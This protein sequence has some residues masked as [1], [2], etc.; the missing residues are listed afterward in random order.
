[1]M[2]QRHFDMKV[3]LPNYVASILQI[4]VV[5]RN[6]SLHMLLVIPHFGQLV[7]HLLVFDCVIMTLFS[8]LD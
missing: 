2:W 1:M 5:H 6:I 8:T 4:E 3:Q 7:N